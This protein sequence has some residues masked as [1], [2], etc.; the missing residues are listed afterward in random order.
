MENV[1]KALD[2]VICSIVSS[3]EYKEC[4]SLKEKMKE[5]QEIM[6]LIEDVKKL[7]KKYIRSQYD[8]SVK[9]ELDSCIKRLSEIPIYHAYQE[10]LE[11]VNDKICYVKESMN[12]YFFHLLNP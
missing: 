6:T 11:K 2:E 3:K 4:I 10:S 9:E 5:N 7:Q 8:S 1:Y 12:D